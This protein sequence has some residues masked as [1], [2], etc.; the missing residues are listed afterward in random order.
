MHV[1]NIQVFLRDSQ[2]RTQTSVKFSKFSN[3]SFSRSVRCGRV[4][5]LL[6]KLF[7]KCLKAS[8]SVIN[9]VSS[10]SCTI[11]QAAHT[12][13][14]RPS[15]SN[16]PVLIVLKE[17]F[18]SGVKLPPS[19]N[20]RTVTIIRIQIKVVRNHQKTAEVGG[21]RDFIKPREKAA[22]NFGCGSVPSFE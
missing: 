7:A 20:F 4:S 11:W 6:R 16:R 3:N 21:V 2:P 14:L 5:N 15:T 17:C 19:S 13:K 8:Y 9:I 12:K 22:F 18:C 10:L 1:N